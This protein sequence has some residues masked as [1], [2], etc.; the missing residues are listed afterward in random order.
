MFHVVWNAPKGERGEGSERGGTAIDSSSERCL[1]RAAATT[2]ASF[3]SFVLQG[4]PLVQSMRGFV[5]HFYK[6]RQ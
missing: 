1:A 4:V 2:V 5:E 6:F 3:M